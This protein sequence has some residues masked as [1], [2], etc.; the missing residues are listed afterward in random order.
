[1]TDRIR[2]SKDKKGQHRRG[3]IKPDGYTEDPK[4]R[5]RIAEEL[6]GSCPNM[7]TQAELQRMRHMS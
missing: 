7:M 4:E 1:M 3:P 6:E 5:V 2:I